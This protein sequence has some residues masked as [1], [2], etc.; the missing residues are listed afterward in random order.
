[1]FLTSCDNGT[2]HWLFR[3]EEGRRGI[4]ESY[5]LSEAELRKKT[6]WSLNTRLLI[7]AQRMEELLQDAHLIQI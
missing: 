7:L 1:M 5:K 3:G 6:S 4:C 2:S